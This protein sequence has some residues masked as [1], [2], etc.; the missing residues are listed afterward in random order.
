MPNFSIKHKLDQKI[1][2]LGNWSWAGGLDELAEI[3]V[4]EYLL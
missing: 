4:G 3:E 2:M 1:M